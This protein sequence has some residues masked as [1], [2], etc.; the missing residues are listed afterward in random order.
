MDFLLRDPSFPLF[1][2]VPAH[3]KARQNGLAQ[4]HDRRAPNVV[5]TVGEVLALKEHVEALW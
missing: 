4:R 2:A 5:L 1:P 3:T